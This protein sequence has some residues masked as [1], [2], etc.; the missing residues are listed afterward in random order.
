M[1][2]NILNK[3]VAGMDAMNLSEK[4][5]SSTVHDKSAAESSLS[6]GAVGR[7]DPLARYAHLDEKKILRKVSAC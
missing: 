6:D 2:I 4:Y 1:P 7:G 3:V 5:G